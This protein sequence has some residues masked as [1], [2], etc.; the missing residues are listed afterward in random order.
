MTKFRMVARLDAIYFE[1]AGLG[2]ASG[3][4]VG[5]PGAAGAVEPAGAGVV[6][7]AAA[8]AAVP[9]GAVVPAGAA[10]PAG[11]LAGAAGDAV[12]LMIEDGP[13]CPMIASVNAPS[14][15]NTARTV[16]AFVSKV[17]PPRAP[18]AV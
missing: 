6:D 11:A 17:A 10:A 5:F 18:N 12:P 4:A 9:D 1:G 2:A 3:V 7:P 13:R 14:M 15:N 16:V 8:G